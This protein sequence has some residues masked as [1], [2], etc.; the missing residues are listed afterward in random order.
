MSF[1]HLFGPVPRVWKK[2]DTLRRL[3]LLPLVRL[4]TLPGMT[5]LLSVDYP[6]AERARRA[7]DKN[8]GFPGTA[9]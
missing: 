2:N 5:G 4:F 7:R 8:R 1:P 3:F 9:C 6:F